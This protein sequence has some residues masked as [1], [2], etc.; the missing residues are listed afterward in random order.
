MSD[1]KTDKPDILEALSAFEPAQKEQL[2]HVLRGICTDFSESLVE[3]TEHHKKA[4]D[5]LPDL[6]EHC[7][8]ISSRLDQIEQSVDMLKAANDDGEPD[9]R[10]LFLRYEADLSSIRFQEAEFKILVL[11]QS[12]QFLILDMEDNQLEPP[13]E[14]KAVIAAELEHQL[15]DVRAKWYYG[16]LMEV[17]ATPSNTEEDALEDFDL[18]AEGEVQESN[19]ALADQNKEDNENESV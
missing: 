6:L 16:R 5:L 7:N 4:A 15:Q 2:V 8:R 14:Q 9:P 10:G 18:P 11:D 12:N 17:R 3:R 13:E 1:Q 19:D